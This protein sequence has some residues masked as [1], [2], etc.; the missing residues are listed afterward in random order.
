M[1]DANAKRKG[2]TMKP[3]KMIGLGITV[4]SLIGGAVATFIAMQDAK[5]V[6]GLGFMFIAGFSITMFVIGLALI[7]M[8]K[9]GDPFEEAAKAIM[10]DA[11][12][13]GVAT[14]TSH[15]V[16]ASPKAPVNPALEQLMENMA[17]LKRN[18][19]ELADIIAQMENARRMANAP[20]EMQGDEQRRAIIEQMMEQGRS[21]QT[22]QS[23][24]F[25][26]EMER[27]KKAYYESLKPKQTP[28]PL[29]VQEL[30]DLARR[31]QGVQLPV[32]RAQEFD[33]KVALRE[34]SP[35]QEMI[36]R[37]NKEKAVGE[38]PPHSSPPASKP[39]K[40]KVK[41]EI[42]FF[43]KKKAKLQS[44]LDEEEKKLEQEEAVS[45]QKYGA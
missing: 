24:S 8:S 31:M 16:D 38:R 30:N 35:S 37:Y 42:P 10:E 22:P 36:D 26:E 34:Q 5:N 14:K 1:Q 15:I 3:M 6:E 43:G 23:L 13:A 39:E 44:I 27:G 28:Q 4:L 41:F 33:P 19:A 12:S 20:L 29:S 18:N 9:K 32:L 40:V 7:W 17:I 25:E 2:E 21:V 45:R 11:E